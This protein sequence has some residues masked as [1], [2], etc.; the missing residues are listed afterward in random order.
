VFDRHSVVQDDDVLCQGD[1]Y[2]LKASGGVAYSWR[3]ASGFFQ[4]KNQFF[5]VSPADTTAYYVAITEPSGC[6]YAD[7]VVLNVVPHVGP[8][9]TYD[10][11]AECFDRPGIRLTNSS[12]IDEGEQFLFDFGDG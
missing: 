7:T 6:V 9:L 8:K 5:K 3:T 12:Q 4:S 1:E 11:L 2:E 10:I